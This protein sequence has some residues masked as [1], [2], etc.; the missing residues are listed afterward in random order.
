DITL[1][2]NKSYN[3]PIDFTKPV[4]EISL[5]HDVP[6]ASDRRLIQLE[7]QVQRLMEARLAPKPS[8]QV[9]KIASSCEICSGP[10][11]TQYSMENPKQTFVD[12]ASSR[13]D[14]ASGKWFTFKPEKNNLGDTY[15]PS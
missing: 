3:D 9:N 4:K 1:Y 8:V 14:K 12:Y 13:T 7:N 15:N 6:N 10:Y 11:D 5:P 2:D